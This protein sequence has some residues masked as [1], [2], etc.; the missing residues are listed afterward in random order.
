MNKIIILAAGKGTRMD[1]EL[2][3]VLVPVKGEPMIKHLVKEIKESGVCDSPI[4]V[5]SPDNIDIISKALAEFDCEYAIQEKQLGTGHAFSCA[6]SLI[7]PDVKNVIGFYGDHPFVKKETIKSLIDA[8][9]NVLT[10][11]TV[12]VPD[13]EDWRQGFYHWGRVIRDEKGKITGIVEV[14]D[15]DE[16]TKRITEVNPSFFCFDSSWLWKNI[17]KLDNNNN[18]GEYYLTDMAKFAAEEGHLINSL[19]IDPRNA[20]GINSKEELDIAEKIL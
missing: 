19:D 6:R 8:H 4:I 3:K 10:M 18:Q 11:M 12:K 17:Y 20:I 5:V 9:K 7:K 1:C 2:P 15:A 16:K 13:F 14:K